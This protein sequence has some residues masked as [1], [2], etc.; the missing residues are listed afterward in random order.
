MTR[1]FP[2]FLI[3]IGLVTIVEGLTKGYLLNEGEGPPT[4]AEIE[5]FRATPGRRVV[6]VLLGAA[7]LSI[8]LVLLIKH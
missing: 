3:V 4:T 2:V 7:F 8:G 5:K 6:A 1:T